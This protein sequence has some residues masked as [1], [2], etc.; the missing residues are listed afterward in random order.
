MD[1]H[2]PRPYNTGSRSQAWIAAFDRHQ[3]E[4]VYTGADDSLLKGW[5]LRNDMTRP[6]FTVRDQHEAGVCA[7]QSHPQDERY[8]ASGSYDS[9]YIFRAF[10]QGIFALYALFL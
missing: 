10:M 6:I 9:R 3:P 5:D 4:L 7:L 1:P 2:S 8:L